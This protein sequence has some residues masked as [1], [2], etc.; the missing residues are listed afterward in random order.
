MLP[1]EP[2]H[3]S[4]IGRICFEAFKSIHDRHSFPRDFP[5][6][7]LALK[8][9][10]M[11]VERKDF[12]GVVALLDGKPVGSNFLSLTDPVA[13]L[14]PIT[15][16]PA[17]QTRGIGRALMQN[18]IDYGRRNNIE[19]VRLLQDSFNMASL[20]LYSSLG[21][22]VKETV[23]LM[24]AAPTTKPDDSVRL[25]METD[26]PTVEE[27][28]KRIYKVSRRNEVAA[29]ALYGF[30]AFLRA[31]EG[32]IAGYLIPG[33]FGHGVS[34]TEEDA[35]VLIGESARRLPPEF[36]R[37]FCPLR[38]ANLYLNALKAGHRAIKVMNLMAMGPY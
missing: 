13:G 12:Y 4:E 36:A 23:V 29:T 5:A 6:L 32:R 31:R 28:S 17:C 35:L 19:Q 37:F 27:L 16:D 7:D 15:V 22:D 11:L 2:Q 24:Q 9:V 10:D 20:S 38:E 1:A 14:G 8:V 33:F 26:L 34:E 30:P 18:V 3:V 21:F 25:V